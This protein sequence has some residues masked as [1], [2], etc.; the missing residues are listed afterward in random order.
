MSKFMN[1]ETREI[2]KVIETNANGVLLQIIGTGNNLA[3]RNSALRRWWKEIEVT[4]EN[5]AADPAP[6]DPASEIDFSIFEYPITEIASMIITNAT[7]QGCTIKA[8]KSYIGVKF[9]KKTVMEIHTTKKG[10]TKI[11]VNSQSVVGSTMYSIT[12]NGYGKLAP[13]SYGWT[14]DLTVQVDTL[15]TSTIL[16]LLDKG[17]AFR[18]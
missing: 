5:S 9:G 12:S 3:V 6:A 14:L 1:I 8:T 2:G 15:T 18:R 4:S 13:E 10:K 7:R 11:V 16:E 17:I